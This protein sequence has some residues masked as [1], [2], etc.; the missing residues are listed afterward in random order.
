MTTPSPDPVD[1]IV[2]AAGRCRRLGDAG[3]DRPKWLLDVGGRTIADRHLE[4]FSELSARRNGRL[5]TVAVVTGHRADL[6]ESHAGDAVRLVHN[7]D[8]LV[9]NNWYS[10]LVGLRALPDRRSRV[11]VVNGDLCAPVPWVVAFLEASADT[12]EQGLLAID[13]DRRLTDESMKVSSDG[14]R[15]ALIGKHDFAAT[16]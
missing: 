16:E 12:D 7:P 8:Y 11:V 14:D 6:V 3:D 10:L 9:R 15:L 5:R 13:F 4:A 2:L 1:I